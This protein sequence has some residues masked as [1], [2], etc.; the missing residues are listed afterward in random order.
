MIFG[1]GFSYLQAGPEDD[2]EI[3]ALYSDTPMGS[4]FRVRFCRQPSFF[5]A[6]PA[7]GKR[8]T[9]L[10]VRDRGKGMAAGMGCLSVRDAFVNGEPR[11]IGYLS[12]LRVRPEY[13]G[14]TVTAGIYR[15]LRELPDG[16]ALPFFTTT[17]VDGNEP[18][19]AALTSG[20]AGL[21]VYLPWGRYNV[22]A[23]D[24]GPWKRGGIA[25]AGKGLRP[26]DPA[27]EEAGV[28][29]S[30]AST[31][32]MP[33]IASWLDSRGRAMQFRPAMRGEVSTTMGG[34]APALPP[35][36]KAGDFLVA[37]RIH[38]RAGRS[39]LPDRDS[40]TGGPGS[41]GEMAGVIALWDQRGFKQDV[42]EGYPPWLDIMRPLVNLASPVVG[43]TPL[44]APGSVLPVCFGAFPTADDNLTMKSL[45]HA[46]SS[47]AGA[48]GFG[49]LL[50]GFHEDDP[51]CL[52][53]TSF[54]RIVYR[55]GLYVAAWK[56]RIG[57]M[58]TIDR[59]RIPYL[60][61]G[62]L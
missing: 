37:R 40:A 47:M 51:R 57:E 60:E 11:E 10:I 54:R 30:P 14:G 22:F 25:L 50:L 6:L 4:F 58:K 31:S 44:P 5:D 9:V 33:E 27:G 43:F 17:I 20:R 52:A 62:L 39:T 38:D 41:A 46:A 42:I 26:S 29:I 59:F 15:F 61:A 23:I 55:S 16:G 35:G 2:E 19:A 1:S 49:M 56:D 45:V 34:S 3:R 53:L 24:L 48:R 32:E 7:M 13:Q 12:S 21:P 18:A 28:S 8:N 36:I